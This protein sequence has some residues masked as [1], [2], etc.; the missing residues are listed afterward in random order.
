MDLFFEGE[1]VQIFEGMEVE[2]LLIKGGD[3]EELVEYLHPEK[4]EVGLLIAGSDI[5]MEEGVL[6]VQT[7]TQTVGK[8]DDGVVQVLTGFLGGRVVAETFDQSPH[9]VGE[10]ASE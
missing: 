4:L 9:K 6:L 7:H 8:L 3:F 5:V 10:E 2:S 1:A